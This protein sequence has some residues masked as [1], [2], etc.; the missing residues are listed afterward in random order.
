VRKP[1]TSPPTDPEPPPCLPSETFFPPRSTRK[2]PSPSESMVSFF[3]L[4]CN[5][6]QPLPAE[7][8][9]TV[10][11]P[12]RPKRVTGMPGASLSVVL[13]IVV[14]CMEN[15]HPQLLVF[16]PWSCFTNFSP[17]GRLTFHTTSELLCL[18]ADRLELHMRVFTPLLD[19]SPVEL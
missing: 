17:L 4:V 2:L 9:T 1:T 16:K 11:R 7:R 13:F 15:T 6:D 5:R 3:L 8:S 12:F 18:A 14:C 10:F 19:T